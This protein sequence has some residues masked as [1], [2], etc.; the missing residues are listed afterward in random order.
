[1]QVASD[2]VI[3]PLSQIRVIY[4]G[5]ASGLTGYA[6]VVQVPV[7]PWL[8]YYVT[9]TATTRPR[10]APITELMCPG[11]RILVLRNVFRTI[12]SVPGLVGSFD[13]LM[14]AHVTRLPHFPASTRGE[15]SCLINRSEGRATT[16]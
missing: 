4:S 14:G 2:D 16:T 7:I 10:G 12:V 3:E 5:A 13:E 1:M 11:A 8:P 15:R 9:V 6:P